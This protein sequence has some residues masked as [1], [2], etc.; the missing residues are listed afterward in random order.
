MTL[1]LQTLKPSVGQQESPVLAI[2]QHCDVDSSSTHHNATP[3]APNMGFVP[4]PLPSTSVTPIDALPDTAKNHQIHPQ[5]FPQAISIRPVCE[6]STHCAFCLRR[7]GPQILHSTSQDW[8]PRNQKGYD[9]CL[10]CRNRDTDSLHSSSIG[11]MSGRFAQ[12]E[13]EARVLCRTG[14]MWMAASQ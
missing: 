5:A 2:L 12:D 3:N 8:R 7:S 10:R 13:T 9:S 14:W 11:Q 1:Q 4:L 6:K